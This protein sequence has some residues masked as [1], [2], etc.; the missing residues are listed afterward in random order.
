LEQNKITIAQVYMWNYIR[1]HICTVTEADL[2]TASDHS[3]KKPKENVSSY[4]RR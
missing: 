3:P 1:N 4:S 2:K